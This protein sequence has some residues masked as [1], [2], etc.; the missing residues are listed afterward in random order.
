MRLHAA[1]PLGRRATERILQGA[2]GHAA[3]EGLLRDA[4]AA[5]QD[6]PLRGEAAALAHY[7]ARGAAQPR[8][9]TSGSARFRFPA[10]VGLVK[11]VAAGGATAAAIGAVAMVTGGS[12][13]PVLGQVLG[14]VGGQTPATVVAGTTQSPRAAAPTTGEPAR[15]VDSTP[16]AAPPSL[17]DPCRAFLIAL[18]DPQDA[19]ATGG[20]DGAASGDQASGGSGEPGQP[21]G[22]KLVSAPTTSGPTGKPA[23]GRHRHHSSRHHPSHSTPSPT[24]SP[25]VQAPAALVAAA[26]GVE[27]VQGFCS[28]VVNQEPAQSTGPAATGMPSPV[29]TAP[30]AS[31]QPQPS[32]SHGSY[33]PGPDPGESSGRP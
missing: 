3:L 19:A 25:T 32:R 23:G 12:D 22:D 5:P 11:V 17:V 1:Q 9:V 28:D 4:A 6:G 2:G 26:G 20:Q 18:Q 31:T 29:P 27:K 7:R 16:I 13:V 8:S 15:Q 14:Q 21:S 10:A 30:P 33:G 24:P